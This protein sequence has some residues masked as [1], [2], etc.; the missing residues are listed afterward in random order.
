MLLL[1]LL[2]RMAQAVEELVRGLAVLLRMALAV[3]ELVRGWAVL[4]RAAL[5]AVKASVPVK[6]PLE[7]LLSV[8]A[9]P[10]EVMAEGFAG[11]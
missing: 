8:L 7:M 3:E 1:R 11:T 5:L 2:L 6:F 10:A 9:K 4:L